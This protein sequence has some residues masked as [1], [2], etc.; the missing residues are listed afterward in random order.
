[1]KYYSLNEFNIIKKNSKEFVLES[2]NGLEIELDKKGAL[3]FF[4]L[5]GAYT[6]KFE[7]IVKEN[8][9]DDDYKELLENL[10]KIR[11]IEIKNGDSSIP[12]DRKIAI[13]NIDNIEKGPLTLQELS[14]T[15]SDAC[16]LNCTY[17]FRKMDNI[18][19]RLNRETVKKIILDFRKLAG[20][21]LNI[22]GGE[23]SVFADEVSFCAK[24]ARE[25]GVKYI[26]VNSS[27]FGLTREKLINWKD[28]G[29][30]C[31]NLSFDTLKEEYSEKLLGRKDGVKNCLN[32]VKWAGE[33]GLFVHINLTLT[34]KNYQEIENFK[35]ILMRKNISMRV[36]PYVPLSEMDTISPMIIKKGYEIVEKMRKKGIP[37]YIPI[38]ENENYPEAFLCSGGLT[39][40]T[41]ENNGK[42]GGCQFLMSK[43]GPK[44]NVVDNGLYKLWLEGNFQVFRDESE[45]PMEQCKECNLRPFCIGN[46]LAVHVG[47]SKAENYCPLD[48]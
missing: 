9:I 26:S 33:I 27:G 20:I 28:S 42:I 47:L 48:K 35:E 40:A 7:K 39:R 22:S 37:I 5:D 24:F 44:G 32:V 13:K 14:I 29:I 6:D 36:N 23:P 15:L 38:D 1:M 31:I 30:E 10:I 4:L 2:V 16:P 3:F 25:N 11:F 45:K 41:V 21:T 17:C 12:F 8:G 19:G 18:R 34:D 43:Y 46:C